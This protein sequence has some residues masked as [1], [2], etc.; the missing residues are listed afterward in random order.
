LPALKEIEVMVQLS[1]WMTKISFNATLQQTLV[2]EIYKGDM[3]SVAGGRERPQIVFTPDERTGKVTPYVAT[4][5]Q[6]GPL[7]AVTLDEI[8]EDSVQ[9]LALDFFRRLSGTT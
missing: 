4:T 9:R 8:T 1:G 6:G 5:S 2:F 3:R 7:S